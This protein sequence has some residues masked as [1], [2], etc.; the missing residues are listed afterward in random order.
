MCFVTVPASGYMCFVTVPCRSLLSTNCSLIGEII[1]HKI[2]LVIAISI[3]EMA[4]AES[5]ETGSPTY[6][7][8][9]SGEVAI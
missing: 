2:S 5:G 7:Q 1:V 6:N 3:V 8:A 4:S 9:A